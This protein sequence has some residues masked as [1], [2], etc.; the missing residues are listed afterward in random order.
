MGIKPYT[1]VL[2]Y[3][4]DKRM[5][6]AGSLTMTKDLVR[7]STKNGSKENIVVEFAFSTVR[8]YAIPLYLREKLPWEGEPEKKPLEEKCF[9]IDHMV[10]TEVV[11]EYLCS[12]YSANDVMRKYPLINV[13]SRLAVE[14]WVAKIN[15]KILEINLKAAQD[16]LIKG[17][18]KG[19]IDDKILMPIKI[20]VRKDYLL[21]RH[22]EVE[23]AAIGLQSKEDVK[24]KL[25]GIFDAIVDKHCVGN[26]L[27][28]DA[29]NF[30]KNNG[31]LPLQFNKSKLSYSLEN[32]FFPKSP[33]IS[34]KVSVKLSLTLGS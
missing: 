27:C 21:Q 5:V 28:K 2:E 10:D 7:F 9:K 11:S 19:T 31:L 20:T 33:N 18:I 25:P 15:L 34:L 6:L 4:K 3:V 26:Q 32:P 24:K 8:G 17:N 14:L 23:K 13:Q 29:I 30:S 16:K 22:F 12:Y 1:G